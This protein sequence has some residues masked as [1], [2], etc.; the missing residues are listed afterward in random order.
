MKLS[1]KILRNRVVRLLISRLAALYIRLAYAGSR[2]SVV[3]GEIPRQLWDGNKPFILAFWHGR[4]LMMPYCWNHKANI[5]MLVSEHADGQLGAD[6]MARLGIKSVAGSST[7]G[8]SKALRALLQVIR[9]GDCVAV[10]PDG[11][12]GPRMRAGNGI[13]NLARLSGVPIIPVAFGVTRG[14]VVSSWDRFLVAFPSARGVMVW[15]EPVLVP[16]DADDGAVE[17]ARQRVEDA[18][19]AVTAEADILS[20]R[21]PV[22]PAVETAS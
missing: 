1:K 20:G 6:A 4:M 5:Y 13:I 15:G 8:G 7:R 17:E 14:K 22:E 16:R 2:W 9:S 12:R 11:P 3:R 10:A 19:N 21:V 18:L